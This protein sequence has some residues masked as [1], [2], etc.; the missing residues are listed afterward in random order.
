MARQRPAAV[1]VMGILNIVFGSLGLLCYICGGIGLLMLFNSNALNLPG[2]INPFEDMKVFMSRE[3]PAYWPI[4]I[5]QIVL[6]FIMSILL[7]VAG[8]GLLNMGGWARVLSIIYSIITI[9]MQIGGLIF[10]LAYVNP[11]MERWQQQFMGRVG[12]RLPPGAM[13][14]ADSTF[15]NLTSVVGAIIGMVYAIVLLIMMLQPRV[16]AAF[17]GRAAQ[18]DYAG[19]TADEGDDYE[20]RRRR[21]QWDY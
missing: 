16:S 10:T 17:S 11:A 20:R 3:V 4:A 6:G 18:D 2:G 7:L 21:D 8:I 1:T 5:G 14:G 19:G 9:L 12:G 15:N 13:G